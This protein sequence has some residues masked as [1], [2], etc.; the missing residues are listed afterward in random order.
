VSARKR[1]PRSEAKPSEGRTGSGTHLEI[2]RKYLLRSFPELPAG[3]E[4][5][6]IE[7]GWLPASADGTRERL[8]RLATR[9]GVRFY[10]T[11]KRGSGL[12]RIEDERELSEQEFAQK[13]PRTAGCR[14]RKERH[15][16][17]AGALTWE[18]DRFLGLPLVLAEIELPTEDARFETPA[19]LAPSIVREVTLDGRYTNRALAETGRVPVE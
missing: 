17:A 11:I 4:R 5:T 13:W 16:V 10:S 15:R 1:S 14:I 3:S 2:E 12:T 18:I 9:A 8:R 7:Q 19:W 6:E